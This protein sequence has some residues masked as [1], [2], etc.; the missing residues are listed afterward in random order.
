MNRYIVSY[1]RISKNGKS[2]SE[3]KY[4]VETRFTCTANGLKD[5]ICTNKGGEKENIKI[6][7]VNI[8]TIS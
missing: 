4:V 7:R 5:V 6:K 3:H 8:E 1:T 2:V